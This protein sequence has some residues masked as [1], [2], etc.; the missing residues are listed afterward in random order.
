M[1][2]LQSTEIQAKPL[3]LVHVLVEPAPDNYLEDFGLP[4]FLEDNSGE[5]S[6]TKGVDVDRIFDIQQSF[7]DGKSGA[8]QAGT[9]G[10]GLHGC[11][12]LQVSL[13]LYPA[14]LPLCQTIKC[15]HI[16]NHFLLG[17]I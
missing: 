11:D 9:E 2:K 3:P 6:Q 8:G 16:I 1:E 13:I 12:H 17:K 15:V 7:S 14:T 4:S 5:T 10:Q